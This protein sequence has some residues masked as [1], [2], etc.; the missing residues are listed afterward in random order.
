MTQRT[1]TEDPK[2]IESKINLAKARKNQVQKS[3]YLKEPNKTKQIERFEMEINA[4][5]NK[6][7]TLNTQN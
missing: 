6:L 5:Q 7:E 2:F 3:D 1:F 4:L